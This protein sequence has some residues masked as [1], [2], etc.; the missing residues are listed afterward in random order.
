MRSATLRLTATA[1]VTASALLLAACGGTM[2]K[3][4]QDTATGAAVGAVAG[5]VVGSATGGKAGQSAVIGGVL[6]AVAGNLWSK[7]MQDKQRELEQATAGTGAT[8]TR[9]EDNQIKVVAPADVSFASG[10]AML[11]PNMRPILDTLAKDLDAK[12]RLT[13]A[14]HTDA[15][16]SDAVNNTLSL[17]RAKTVRDYLVMRGVAT[18]R[19]AVNGYG[20]RMP[21]ADN[22]TDAGRAQNRRVEI[23][24]AQAG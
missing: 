22:A 12:S 4:E 3:R 10:S 7:H 23:T 18:D 2:S 24:L 8:V 20:S 6:G 9:T 14:G 15:T 11:N 17:E 13:V 21:V 19:I 1:V 5:A 16:G